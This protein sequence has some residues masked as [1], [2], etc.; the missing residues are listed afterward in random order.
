MRNE[1]IKPK[2]V[3]L[4]MQWPFG[5]SSR[6]ARQG[7]MP[8]IVLPDGQIRFDPAEVENI[9]AN[10]REPGTPRDANR[11]KIELT[12]ISMNGGQK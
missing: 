6:L 1:L 4:I 10:G 12:A 3:D 2:D 8:H 5:K 7:R 9:L 11:I